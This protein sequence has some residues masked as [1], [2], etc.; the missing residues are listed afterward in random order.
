MGGHPY[1]QLAARLWQGDHPEFVVDKATKLETL[2]DRI[3]EIRTRFEVLKCDGYIEALAARLPAS[4]REA[5]RSEVA[6]LWSTLDQEFAFVAECNLGG[7]W[8]AP[9][10]LARLDA[11]A[12]RTWLRTLD[13]RLGISREELKLRQNEPVHHCPA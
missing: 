10:K 11:I 6:P 8:M 3:H 13:D 7:E 1:R 5:A 12:S 9:E 2:Y 4:E